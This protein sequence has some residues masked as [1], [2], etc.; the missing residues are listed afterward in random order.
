M[1]IEEERL[2]LPEMR[3]LFEQGNDFAPCTLEVPGVSKH[4]GELQSVFGLSRRID[5][6]QPA[7]VFGS[8]SE[9][10][11]R[12]R[13]PGAVSED[14]G[15][16]GGNGER[17]GDGFRRG[18]PVFS[19]RVQVGKPS[20]FFPGSRARFYD[21][22]QDRFEA[23]RRSGLFVKAED[24]SKGGSSTHRIGEKGFGSSI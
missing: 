19:L 15:V 21:L 11:G 22:G 20:G 24:P 9:M 23:V 14:A 5:S 2:G 4:A 13:V 17:A 3:S 8:C 1:E 18:S 16:E 6:Y 10:A 7:I 12:L